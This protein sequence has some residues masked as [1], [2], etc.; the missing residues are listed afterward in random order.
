MIAFF[1]TWVVETIVEQRWR[2][3]RVA[4]WQWLLFGAFAAYYLLTILYY[5][6]EHDR[7]YWSEQVE[8]RVPFIVFALIG[9][10]GVNKH[11]RFREFAWVGAAVS[12]YAVLSIL[13]VHIGW[14]AL[15]NDPAPKNL[16]YSTFLETYGPH[17][18]WNLYMNM[19]ILMLVM[20]WGDEQ[21]PRWAQ[22]L[23]LCLIPPLYIAITFSIGRI[24]VI[25]TQVLILLCLIR[26]IP[27]RLQIVRW[28][29]VAVCLI[30]AIFLVTFNPRISTDSFQNE[31]PRKAF[32]PRCI[33]MIQERPLIGRGSSSTVV[34]MREMLTEEMNEEIVQDEWLK[35]YIDNPRTAIW[36]AHP[37]N[38]W[39]QVAMEYGVSGILCTMLIL[40]YPFYFLHRSAHPILSC[41][42]I[43][44]INMQ[45]M[46]ECF[47]VIGTNFGLCFYLTIWCLIE[48]RSQTQ[49]NYQNTPKAA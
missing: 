31:N 23:S 24:G 17:M 4:R 15:Q 1:A 49:S 13:F 28:G 8:R 48:M 43:F 40:L 12:I 22:V 30:G 39:L 26:L 37:H 35:K 42:F 16:Y 36:A 14:E 9:I 5:P 11:Y 3:I 21:L 44:A 7:T 20:Q 25:T 46:T 6:I 41:G 10:L 38:Q 29:I 47:Q 18:E 45:L 19:T 2:E 32:W 34:E 33:E 27:Q